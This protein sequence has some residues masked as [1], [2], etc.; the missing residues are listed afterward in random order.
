LYCL[1]YCNDYYSNQEYTSLS[2]HK[3]YQDFLS[4]KKTNITNEYNFAV[5]DTGMNKDQLNYLKDNKVI[6]TEAKWNVKVPQYKILGRNHLK[7]QVAR[8]YLPNYFPDYKIYIWL[9]ADLWLN[10]VDTFILYEKGA[11]KDSLAITPQVDRA[12]Y[13]LASVEWFFNFPKRIKTI[14]YKNIGKSVSNALAK[15]YAFHATLNAGAFAIKSNSSIWDIF[16]KNIKLAARK[17]RIFGTDQVALA[18]SVYEDK[19]STEF[20]PS[21]CN[22]MCE[23]NLPMFDEN[24]N[25]FVEPYIPNHPLALIHLAGLDEIRKNKNILSNLKT[26]KGNNIK[27]SLRFN[28]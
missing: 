11:L 26:L 10:D 6:I 17:G 20:L 23:F 13:K 12:Y 18:L 7:T 5:L 16:Q 27:K 1:I 14:N 22:W 19:I 8:A 25:L 3:A 2:L 9:D 21:Y 15:K 28:V 24:N 4:I